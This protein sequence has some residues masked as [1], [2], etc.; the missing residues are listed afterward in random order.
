M[1]N[2]TTLTEELIGVRRI[3][4]EDVI[5]L[6]AALHAGRAPQASHIAGGVGRGSRWT[7][8]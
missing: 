1:T 7:S 8:A 3:M 6:E 5:V 2:R 4:T